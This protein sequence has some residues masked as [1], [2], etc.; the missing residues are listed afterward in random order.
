[1]SQETDALRIVKFFCI[2]KFCY[3]NPLFMKG[4]MRARC[5]RRIILLVE[6]A[7]VAVLLI[8][9][10][11]NAGFDHEWALDQNGIWARKYQTALENGVVAVE[12]AGS[13]RSG[14][15]DQLGH[16]FGRRW[17]PRSYRQP[18]PRR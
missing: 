7:A 14:N 2:A 10:S 18:A 8:S 11:A 5:A 1:M 15:N 16:T 9:T 17:T 12:L 13:L 3:M 4:P 6:V